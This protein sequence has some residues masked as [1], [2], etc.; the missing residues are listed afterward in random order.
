M[1][2][3]TG[4]LCVSF[5]SLIL[6]NSI[7]NASN[8]N[9]EPV[10]RSPTP[11]RYLIASI[12][13]KDPMTPPIAPMT[14][15]CLQVG[16]ASFG[17]ATENGAA[18]TYAYYQTKTAGT[19]NRITQVV[20]L[21]RPY[22][23]DFNNQM[24]MYTCSVISNATVL[25]NAYSGEISVRDHDAKRIT[26]S[27]LNIAVSNTYADR[28]VM[29]R[30]RYDV[31]SQ[32]SI[33]QNIIQVGLAAIP[34]VGTIAECFRIL[35]TKADTKCGYEYQYQ[36]TYD[37]Q[38]TVYGKVVYGIVTESQSLK[39]IEDSAS[40]TLWGNNIQN[41]NRVL[42]GLRAQQIRIPYKAILTSTNQHWTPEECF[43]EIKKEH[44]QMHGLN[45]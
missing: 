39:Y 16:T 40:V 31:C 5:G 17:G 41:C 25:Y 35:T 29:I 7:V 32:S 20:L 21:D 22:Y 36:D 27:N 37:K 2:P 38:M 44:E 45:Q 34:K 10:K 14:P 23:S 6:W 4:H 12:A 8:V 18:Y 3:H 19:E 43:I 1:S 26:V 33:M 42:A 9:R 24:F 28:G 13:C 11:I 30:G 15:A